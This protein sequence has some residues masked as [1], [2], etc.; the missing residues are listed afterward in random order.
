V[1]VVWL[2]G[3]LIFFFF[4]LHSLFW[5]T[6]T[7]RNC[8]VP[9]PFL[10]SDSSLNF[11]VLWQ[12]LGLRCHFMSCSSSLFTSFQYPPTLQAVQHP[13]ILHSPSLHL[14][15]PFTSHISI[16]MKTA[17]NILK[18]TSNKKI[19]PTVVWQKFVF[20]L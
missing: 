19:D 8:I 5:D 4:F 20:V 14:F 10:F 7:F 12:F 16:L 18:K 11:A 3:C 17:A 1:K 6:S 2:T 13:A 9:F 15:T